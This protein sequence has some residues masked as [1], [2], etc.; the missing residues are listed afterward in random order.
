ME[1]EVEPKPL[2][3]T[4]GAAR[5]M[6]LE[7]TELTLDTEP[8]EERLVVAAVAPAWLRYVPEAARA[9]PSEPTTIGLEPDQ[10]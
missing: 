8:I 9:L 5:L 4:E 1:L 6:E 10:K 2:R 7:L 3:L